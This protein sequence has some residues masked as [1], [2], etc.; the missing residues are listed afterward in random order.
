MLRGKQLAGAPML[1]TIRWRQSSGMILAF[2][3]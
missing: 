1:Q 3:L 2:I